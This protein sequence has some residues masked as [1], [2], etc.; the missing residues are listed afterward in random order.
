MTCL[1]SA[2]HSSHIFSFP[3]PQ[4]KKFSERGWS[5]SKKTSSRDDRTI[6]L[7]LPFKAGFEPR[8]C[9]LVSGYEELGAGMSHF[10]SP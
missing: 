5:S 9:T 7:C 4:R 2:E 8:T 10:G 1:F 6:S 3:F